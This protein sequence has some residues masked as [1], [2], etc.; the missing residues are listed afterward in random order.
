MMVVNDT[1][2]AY[3]LRREI[4]EQLICDGHKVSLMCQIL[5]F[6]EELEAMGVKLIDV[7][8]NRRG[9]NPLSDLRLFMKYFIKLRKERPDLILGNNIK[10]NAY[11]GLACRML[12][13][14]RICNITGLGTALEQ[15][16]PLQK[17]TILLYKMGTWNADSILFQNTEN[18]AFFREHEML[19]PK[20][21]VVLLPGSGVNIET[22]CVHPYNESEKI[23]FLYV[24]RILKEKGIDLYLSAA[25]ESRRRYS[26]TQ[27]HICGM[28]DDDAYMEILKKAEFDGDI[29]YHGEQKK[30]DSFFE[31][32]HCVVHPS[33][34]PEGMSNVLLEAAASGRPAIATDR[35]GCREIVNDGSSGYVIPIKDENALIN[36]LER[37][38]GL[39]WQ[40]RRDMGLAGRKKVEEEFD[41]K[42]VVKMVVEEIHKCVN[43]AA[44]RGENLLKNV[45]GN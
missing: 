22:H 10:P 29:I 39:T 19:S 23:N 36:A 21:R 33:Y 32:A 41:R 40:E 37:F 9:T 34:Y 35:S 2:F 18:E 44:H 27:F 42:I 7:K 16:G 31:M 43:N 20:S 5:S 12:N 30:M 17:L 1:T 26:N 25:K 24:A 28:C 11:A 6:Q 38:M 14:R 45:F 13:I 15:P 8:N 3:N 4:L